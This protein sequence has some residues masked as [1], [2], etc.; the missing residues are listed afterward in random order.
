MTVVAKD[1]KVLRNDDVLAFAGVTRKVVEYQ[2]RIFSLLTQNQDPGDPEFMNRLMSVDPFIGVMTAMSGK[3]VQTWVV[4]EKWDE[5]LQDWIPLYECDESCDGTQCRK[6][7]AKVNEVADPALAEKL[8]L[9][10]LNA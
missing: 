8:L 1:L 9:D 7:V 4:E 6:A 5:N 3:Q 2:S 10:Y